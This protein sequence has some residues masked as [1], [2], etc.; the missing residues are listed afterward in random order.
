MVVQRKDA[1]DK[2]TEQGIVFCKFLGSA[3]DVEQE[4]AAFLQLCAS[5]KRNDG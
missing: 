2:K 3:V 5:L 4:R 1:A